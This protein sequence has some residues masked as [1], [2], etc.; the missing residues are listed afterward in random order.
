MWPLLLKVEQ[1]VNVEHVYM[2]SPL[3]DYW[4]NKKQMEAE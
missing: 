2:N 1:K 4:E 3:I